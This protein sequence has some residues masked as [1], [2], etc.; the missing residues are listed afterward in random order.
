MPEPEAEKKIAKEANIVL[1]FEN[2]IKKSKLIIKTP[3]TEALPPKLYD[4]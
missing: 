3:V 4:L 1:H 2:G